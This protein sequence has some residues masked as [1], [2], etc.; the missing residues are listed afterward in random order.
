MGKTY[1]NLGVAL[2]GGAAY[3]AAH[4]GVL[5]AF[6]ELGIKPEYISGTSIG[7]FVAAHY[8]FGTPIDEIEKIGLELDWLDVT[9]IKLSK[10]GLLSNE[11]L[12]KKVIDQIGKVTIERSV[13]P[14]AMIATDICTSNKVVL[15]EGPLHKAVMASTCL[16]GV[17]VPVEWDNMLLVD[18]VLCENVPVSPL[19]EMG[20]VDVIAVDL[21]TNRKYKCPEDIIDVLTN[22]FDIGLNN[23]IREQL[24]NDQTTLIQP[25]LTAYN[26]ADTGKA[27]NLIR[28]GYE[29]T[30]KALG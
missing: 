28:E 6:V 25:E 24:D 23:M 7:A 8:A 17:F 13:I 10:L 11:R 3:G 19:R 1:R 22:T 4:V 18:G 5:K 16:P 30:M 29:A 9:G 21:T 12:G 14:L 20:A 2:G 15:N 26:K 27:E